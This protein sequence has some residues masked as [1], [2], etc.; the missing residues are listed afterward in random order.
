MNLHHLHRELTA[1]ARARD[2][3][4]AAARIA[5]KGGARPENV[6][7]ILNSVARLDHRN[8]Q[9]TRDAVPQIGAIMRSF[10]DAVTP[11]LRSATEAVARLA[12][13]L[14]PLGAYTTAEAALLERRARY[15]GN[16][17]DARNWPHHY[18]TAACSGWLHNSCPSPAQ[19]LG[20]TCTCHKK[21]NHR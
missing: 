11:A 10:A 6:V 3:A 15:G 7:G 20:C 9:L 12:R 4:W 1:N 13:A 2:V 18:L 17:D 14:A 8:A 5:I 16:A 21:G 19:D